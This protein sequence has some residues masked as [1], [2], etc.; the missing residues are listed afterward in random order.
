VVEDAKSLNN[1]LHNSRNNFSDEDKQEVLKR[2]LDKDN[3]KGLLPKFARNSRN[4]EQK[5]C[6]LES[7]KFAYA[8][9]A[10]NKS[11]E[12]FPIKNVLLTIVVSNQIGPS[13][14]FISK[15][16]GG[17]KYLLGKVVFRRIH[18][19]LIGENIWGGLP[20]KRR[21]NVLNETHCQKVL[22]FWD[23]ATT[24]SPIAKDVKW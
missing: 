10:S 24:I 6:L 19:D 9:L 22:D 17:T 3:V 7:L 21:S 23:T 13:P 2:F 16:I 14:C 4:I 11:K 12:N 5:S 1:V 18:V 8:Q 20:Q 15:A